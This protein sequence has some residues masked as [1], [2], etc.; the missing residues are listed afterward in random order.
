MRYKENL[1]LKILKIIVLR[2]SFS[3]SFFP[4]LVKCLAL[5]AEAAIF[6][7]WEESKKRTWGPDTEPWCRAALLKA[8][9]YLCTDVL[10]I[11]LYILV[12]CSLS[13]SWRHANC[14]TVNGLLIVFETL[15]LNVGD[16]DNL[17][18]WL[19]GLKKKKENLAWSRYV[20]HIVGVQ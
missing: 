12:G 4:G 14:L 20:W 9:I 8:S 2:K 13:C 5:W 7:T 1:I 19:R 3:F 10:S 18:K 16:A 11:T 17:Q 6:W 15:L